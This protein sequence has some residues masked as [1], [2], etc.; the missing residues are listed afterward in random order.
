MGVATPVVSAA[1]FWTRVDRP[2]GCRRGSDQQ[3]LRVLASSAALRPL[4]TPHHLSRQSPGRGGSRPSGVASRT[5]NADL[6]PPAATPTHAVE[7]RRRGDVS[8]THNGSQGLGAGSL[9]H[10]CPRPSTCCAGPPL[11]SGPPGDRPCSRSAVAPSLPSLDVVNVR[12]P[13]RLSWVRYVTVWS[14]PRRQLPLGSHEGGAGRRHPEAVGVATPVVSAAAFW[15]HVRPP[16]WLRP[17]HRQTNSVGVCS[18]PSR[19]AASRRPRSAGLR[20]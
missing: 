5:H 19:R 20:P 18:P 17:G 7:E 10:R 14:R 1:A 13:S 12:A 3:L 4:W 8:R 15:T 6:P 16:R 11:R 2:D 9:A